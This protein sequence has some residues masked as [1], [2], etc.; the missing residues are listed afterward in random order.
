[1]PHT[2]CVILG[3]CPHLLHAFVFL[4]VSI[5]WGYC[6]AEMIW[7]VWNSEA[8]PAIFKLH[9]RISLVVQILR[10]HLPMQSSRVPSLAQKESTWCKT[11]KPV[12]HNY[13][14]PL[15]L[16][17]ML[18]DEKPLQ[19]EATA[20]RSLGTSPGE[21]PLLTV[22]RQSLSAATKPQCSQNK[23]FK[24]NSYIYCYD[25]LLLL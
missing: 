19:W 10:I 22:T 4:I 9:S 11:T 14:S 13:W 8:N 24:K 3:K 12:C 20:M 7:H 25:K 21:E 6:T 5:V 1:M 2:S 17:P 15:T 23:F 18:C 16:E